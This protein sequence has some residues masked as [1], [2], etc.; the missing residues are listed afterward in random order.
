MFIT[1]KCTEE[2]MDSTYGHL[3]KPAIDTL[4]SSV[5]KKTAAD[6]K[7]KERNMDLHSASLVNCCLGKD[8]GVLFRL[9]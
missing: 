6:S 8:A 4:D 5:W 3:G 7:P 1:R 9:N 2:L